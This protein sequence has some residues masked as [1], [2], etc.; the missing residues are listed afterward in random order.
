MQ[1]TYPD[2]YTNS[3]CSHPIADVP[4]EDEERDALGVKRAAIRRLNY[5]LGIPSESIPIEN[6][7]Y[8]TRI[9]Y[10]DPGNGKY[11]EH[12]ID[13]ILFIQQDVQIDPNPNEISEISFVPLG[14]LEK[15]LPTLNSC[16]TPWFQLII[17]HRLKLW[18]QNL[19]NL[20][21]Y[22]EHEKIFHLTAD[23]VKI[24]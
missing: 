9:L 13:Y 14:Q 7:T 23:N 5:E 1:V 17:K 15:F 22:K 4:G 10:K 3:C 18:W 19:N 12:E 24:V 21:E 11:G 16:L 2:C 6:I 20:G 8:L